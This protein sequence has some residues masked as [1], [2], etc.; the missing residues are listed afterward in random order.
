MQNSGLFKDRQLGTFRC[1]GV[2]EQISGKP[3]CVFVAAV[4]AWLGPPTV[5]RADS[6][7]IRP[8]IVFILVDDMGYGDLSCTGNKDVNTANIDRLAAEGIRVAQFYVNSPICSPS[9]VAF[10]TGQYPARHLINSYLDSRERNRARGMRDFL[11]PEAPCIARAFEEAGYATA[12]FGK[13]HMGGGR[14]VDDAPLP[15]AY[16]FQ[17]S[18]VSFEGLGDRV[19]PPGGLPAQ[20]ERL[21]QGAISRAPKHRLTE[22]YV[23]RAIDFVKE[24]QD[25]PFYVH[26]WLNDVHDPHET[27]EGRVAKYER[28]KD[29]PFRQRFYAV[30]DEMDGQIGRLVAAIDSLGLARRTLIVLTSD[31]GPTAWPSYYRRGHD[32]PGSTAGFRGRKWSLYEGGIRMPLIARW[33]GTIPAGK[34]NRQTVMAAVDLFPTVAKLAGIETPDVDFDGEDLSAALLGHE[35]VR[36]K[37][38]FWEYGRDG[39]YLQPGKPTDQSPNLAVR[40]GQWKLLVEHDGSRLELYDLSQDTSETN[41]VAERHPEIAERLSGQLLAWRKSLP[42]LPEQIPVRSDPGPTGPVADYP[43]APVSPT[44]IAVEGFWEK[45]IQLACEKIIPVNFRRCEETGR[46]ENFRAAARG[47]RSRFRG[48]MFDDSDVYKVI[49]GAAYALALRPDPELDRRLDQLIAHIAKA[50]EP[51]GYL[52][53]VRALLPPREVARRGGGVRR[54][55]NAQRSHELYCLGHLLEAAVAHYE[56]TGKPALLAVA[57]KAGDMLARTFHADGL[58]IAP[59]HQEVELALVRLYRVT[60]DRRYLDLASFFFELRGRPE[61]RPH[62]G[63]WFRDHLAPEIGNQLVRDPRLYGPFHQDH[64]PVVA[65]RRAVGHTVRGL[66]MYAA[67]ADV[68]A[69]TGNASYRKAVEAIW[70]DLVAGKMFVHGGAGVQSHGRYHEEFTPPYVL[71]EEPFDVDTCTAIGTVFLAHRLNLHA[72]RGQYQDVIERV[73]YNRLLAGVSLDGERYTYGLPL[74]SAGP[75]ILNAGEA[76][77]LGEFADEQ[78]HFRKTWMTVACCPP[79]IARFLP[80]LGQFVY[81]HDAE[82]VY[83]NQFVAG[84][85]TIPFRDGSVTIIQRTDY[86]WDGDVTLDLECQVS[87]PFDLAVRIPGWARNQAFPSDLY[88]FAEVSAREPTLLVDG[89]EVPLEVERGYVHLRRGWDGGHVVRLRLPMPVRRV[90][91]NEKVLS[92]A[93][94]V[95]LQRG[96]VLFACEG[97]DNG[98]E[99]LDLVLPRTSVLHVQRERDLLGDVVVLTGRGQKVLDRDGEGGFKTRPAD[100]TAIPFYAWDNRTPGE[101]TVWLPETPDVLA[102][103]PRLL[104]RASFVGAGS[105][106]SLHDD[107][108]PESSSDRGGFTW[109]PHKGTT[110]W[111]E[112]GFGRPIRVSRVEVYWF[113]DTGRGEC[114]VPVSW[115][116]LHRQGDRW[117]AVDRPTGYGRQRN[118]FNATFFAPVVTETLRLEVQ[119]PEG[120]S[121]GILEWRIE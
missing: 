20:S 117:L 4:A 22:I 109:W 24:N 91:A 28:F 95:A 55:V 45:R 77:V 36:T 10:T 37:P 80:A 103:P 70:S 111:V 35:P 53:T 16:G 74:R 107:V 19:L 12:H 13:W 51:D 34:V 8:N 6:V 90:L 106:G 65:Q 29:N 31:N 46:I 88:R 87:E 50:Q 49:E 101:L 56:A 63:P 42:S 105:L 17:E 72:V 94:K 21:G 43:M 113:D 47:D 120:F 57:R 71:P 85:G 38:I 81:Q 40:E 116:L 75:A 54:W 14:D 11:D 112:Y 30:L 83:V 98:G 119:L 108:V 115:R 5:S 99:V 102:W 78:E 41:N 67:M 96:P 18:L 110:E 97:A 15:Q 26:L 48:T 93:G 33:K 82:T 27:R 100:I 7:P 79:N 32:P 3:V 121:S 66:Y 114:R 118:R 69:L 104:P 61:G 60:G 39:T 1:P 89:A 86:P 58:R 25:G 62:C 52:Y 68:A 9:R 2:R 73:L 84:K 92:V 76:A 23:N 44:N 64:Q 59:G